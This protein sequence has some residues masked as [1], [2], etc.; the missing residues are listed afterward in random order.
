MRSLIRQACGQEPESLWMTV[1]GA[2][3][4]FIIPAMLT[5]YAVAFGWGR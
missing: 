1:A 2:A 4:V 5:L 3:A